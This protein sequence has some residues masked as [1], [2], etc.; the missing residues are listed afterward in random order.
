M[1]NNILK[2]LR[3]L[4]MPL[5][6][7]HKLRSRKKILDSALKLFIAH[8][9]NNV[10]IDKIMQNVNMTRGAFYAHFSSKSELYK[11]SIL[12]AAFNT[13]LAQMKPENISEQEW[14]KKLLKGYLN[15]DH[16]SLKSKPCPLAFLSTDVAVS[17]PEV[18]KAFTT[19]YINMNKTILNYTKTYSSCEEEQTLAITA[20]IIGGAAIARAINDEETRSKLLK[21][22]RETSQKILD[23]A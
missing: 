21:S 1:F 7:E 10:S 2:L 22:C 9:F 4:D 16:I 17:K 8:G 11:E 13:D 5:T 3:I 19:T 20:M 23:G 15:S 14:I 12:N 18:R 6:Q